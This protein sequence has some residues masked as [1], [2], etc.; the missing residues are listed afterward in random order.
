MRLILHLAVLACAAA[1]VLSAPAPQDSAAAAAATASQQCMPQADALSLLDPLFKRLGDKTRGKSV[2][3]VVD[4]ARAFVMANAGQKS[5]APDDDHGFVFRRGRAAGRAARIVRAASAAMGAKAAAASAAADAAADEN[6]A[7]AG[8]GGSGDVRKRA[9][10]STPQ[11][12]GPQLEF[13]ASKRRLTESPVAAVAAGDVVKD[14]S[15]PVRRPPQPTPLIPRTRTRAADAA[16]GRT[17]G[18]PAQQQQRRRTA[19][20]GPDGGG[21][22]RPAQQRARRKSTM[23]RRR[24][25]FS[26][27]GKRASSIGGGFKALPHATVAAADFYRHI[28][29]ELPEPIRLRQLLAW[30][31]RRTS[32]PPEW[33]GGLPEHVK[34]LLSDAVREAAD[35]VHSAFERGEIATSWYHRPVDQLGAAAASAAAAELKPHPENAANR[36]AR[37]RLLARIALLRRE[38]EQWVGE[39]KRAGAEHARAVDR[40][41]KAVQTLARPDQPGA[42]APAPAPIEP[43]GRPLK[44]IDWA[45][46]GADAARY[47]RQADAGEIDAELAAAEAQIARATADLEIQLDAFH[48]DMHRAS[49]AH[50]DAAATCAGRMRD[51]GFVFEQRRARALVAAAAAPKGPTDLAAAAPADLVAAASAAAADPTRDLLRTLAATLCK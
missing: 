29:P 32:E 26:M 35:D 33:P 1:A 46:L 43:I 50:R 7:G 18:R 36:E 31:A 4:E 51:V 2:N 49:E 40:L 27:R 37:E 17:P 34:R 39:L 16:G 13:P 22:E 24:S 12:G 15:V 8:G 3:Q 41:P 25:T 14:I 20:A 42:P 38:N 28:S 19:A 44:S 47:V 21:G 30:C 23:A 5:Q 6:R 48:L 10:G 11:R 9:A 45:P